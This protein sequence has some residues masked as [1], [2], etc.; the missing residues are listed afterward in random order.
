MKAKMI[1][2][3]T[4]DAPSELKAV[5]PYYLAGFDYDQRP[6]WVLEAGKLDFRRVV[7]PGEES[8]ATAKRY[9]F[10]AIFNI[11]RSFLEAD[12]GDKEVRKALVILDMEGFS[13][14]QVNSAP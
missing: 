4:W 7:E 2:L 11:I 8:L 14:K 9:L 6:V 1:N 12:S 13:L 5:F 3:T 10:Q